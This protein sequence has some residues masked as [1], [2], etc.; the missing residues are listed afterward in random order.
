MSLTAWGVVIQVPRSVV[1]AFIRTA[2]CSTPSD[3]LP[4]RESS[5]QFVPVANRALAK[6]KAQIDGPALAL[7]EEVDE[8]FSGSFTS[9]LQRSSVPTACRIQV[10]FLQAISPSS[11]DHGLASRC[12]S[13]EAR[14]S[15]R[16]PRPGLLAVRCGRPSDST[17]GIT[18]G[19]NATASS[20]E[21]DLI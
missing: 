8:P 15:A 17:T 10:Q 19:N 21:Y 18:S 3:W 2:L 1:G 6:M 14:A 11:S 4:P 20:Y 12:P 5:V 7:V 16:P 9:M 13:P